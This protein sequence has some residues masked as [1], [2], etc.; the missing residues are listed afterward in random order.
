MIKIKEKFM[1]NM[2]RKELKMEE[3]NNIQDLIQVL[4]MISFRI[5]EDL[6]LED[7]KKVRDKDLVFLI[8]LLSEQRKYLTSF[9]KMK[10]K[11]F[12]F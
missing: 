4:M 12:I 7:L 6:D 10:L 9:F 8:S 11:M 1:I 2:E 5:W 3:H